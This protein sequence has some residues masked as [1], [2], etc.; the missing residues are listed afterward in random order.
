MT[1]ELRTYQRDHFHSKVNKLIDPEISKEELLMKSII[2]RM[3]QSAEKT[4]S[5]KIG[6]D[7][8]IAELE[9]AEQQYQ[10]VQKRAKQFF[11]E[12][13]RSSLVYNDNK[14]IREHE[15]IKHIT[16]DNCRDQVREWA[17]ALAEE[18]AERTPQGQRIAYLKAIKDKAQD[19]IMEASTPESLTKALDMLVKNVGISWDRSLPALPKK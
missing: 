8:I 11:I 16:P 19:I 18:E 13:S 6:A 3:T 1:K 9:K 2:S 17:H 15:D 14:K 5:K 7:K 10:S 12:K 4:L